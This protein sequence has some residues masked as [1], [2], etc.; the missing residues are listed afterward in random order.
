ME[1]LPHLALRN[2]VRF[3][4]PEDIVRLG[5]TC[6]RMYSV[7]P[8]VVLAK[9]K[10]LGEDSHIH[11]YYGERVSSEPYFDTPELAS[12]VKSL[13][14]SVTWRDQGWGNRK[15]CFY[16]YLM[17]PV[18]NGKPIQIAVHGN[19]FGIAEHYEKSAKVAIHRHPVVTEA[20]PRDFHRFMRRAGGGEGHELRVRNFRAVATMYKL[21]Y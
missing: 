5:R 21:I 4:C 15:G 2:L 1:A 12:T 17:R 19:L 9:E 20:K 14:L 18:A 3:L 8:R 11:E 13:C 6:K 7:M 16:L 10:W